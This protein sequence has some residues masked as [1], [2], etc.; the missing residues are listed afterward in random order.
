MLVTHRVVDVAP[1]RSP[2]GEAAERRDERVDVAWT[3]A[4]A[5][6][7]RLPG[8]GTTVELVLAHPSGIV[9]IEEGTLAGTRIELGSALVGTTSSAKSVTA[10]RRVVDVSGD[11]L[12]Y[13]LAMAAVGVSLTHHLA[14]PLL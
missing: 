11:V 10:L 3:G 9:E 4:E 7:W 5:G 1:R 12:S 6:Y 13:E 8:G 14:V 2:P